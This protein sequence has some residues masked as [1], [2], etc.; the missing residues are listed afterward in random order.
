MTSDSAEQV[1][2]LLR[3]LSF[4]LDPEL[5]CESQALSLTLSIWNTIRDGREMPARRDIDPVALP[6]NLLPHLLL[7]DVLREPALRFRWRLIGTGITNTLGRDSTG[8]YWDE[9]YDAETH[10]EISSAVQWVIRHR[11]PLR[12]VGRAPLPERSFLHSEN[13]NLPLSSDGAAIDMI[14]GVSLYR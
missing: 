14:L 3:S 9:L 11:R 10:A 12:S 7:V 2:G 6:R 4:E 1:E 13:L 5:R 8:R